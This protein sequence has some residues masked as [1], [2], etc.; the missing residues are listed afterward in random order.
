[1]KSAIHHL[2]LSL[3][4]ALSLA[5][6]DSDEPDTTIRMG[7][8]TA[9]TNLDP[10][11][12][13]DAVSSRINRLLYRRMVE[14]DDSGIPIPSLASWK[15][16]TPTHYRFT[17]RDRGRVFHH[18][19][20]LVAKDVK[21]SYDSILDP[22][23]ASPHRSTVEVIQRIEITGD[24]QIDYYLKRPDSLFPGYL[25]IGV[26]PADLLEQKHPFNTNPVGSGSF[27]F[28][29]WSQQ[30]VPKLIRVRDQQPFEF[31]P[32]QDPSVRILKLM[33]GEI[34]MLQNDLP[35]EL[36]AYLAGREGINIQK[37]PGNNFSY[38]GFNLQD[39]ITSQHKIRQ[40]I[41]LGIDRASI[42]RHF[43]RDGARPAQA[44]L[45]PRHWAGA[46]GLKPIAFEPEQAKA[47]LKELGYTIQNPLR[48]TYK[49]STDP[50]RVRLATLI[51]SQ[52]SE[53][54]IEVEV[55]SHDWGTFYG[56][57]KKGRF[58]LYSLAWV[59]IK[60]PDIF[61]YVFH[62]NSTPPDG[63]NRGRF[64]SEIVD[65]FIDRAEAT[66]DFDQK[67]Q[68]YQRL[69]EQLL[70]ELPYIPLWYEDHLFISRDAVTGYKLASD[71]NYDGLEYVQKKSK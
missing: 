38:L 19:K 41:A 31:L 47:L 59:G 55:Q 30:G 10:R 46:K 63:A 14:F 24:D 34:D 28:H 29:S 66:S 39:E 51:Q 27:S 16:I 21:A 60:T 43:L 58:Q 20:R 3:F 44:L 65:L 5:A 25:H 62:S 17:L 33:R 70:Q 8:T 9:P 71:G 36:M 52:L 61:R 11:F 4:I 13:T 40:A 6:C 49:T 7:L 15:Q 53:I 23:T 18:G 45:P 12:A 69:Q 32:V 50:F 56:D 42:I 68:Y 37:R 64:K 67:A 26:L 2:I 35:P 48:I 22:K 57:V 54:G 1:M